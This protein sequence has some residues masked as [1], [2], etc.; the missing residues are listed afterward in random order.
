M[1]LLVFHLNF[2]PIVETVKAVLGVID[3]IENK[4]HGKKKL[5]LYA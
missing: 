4:S 1:S 3:G 2:G 5:K